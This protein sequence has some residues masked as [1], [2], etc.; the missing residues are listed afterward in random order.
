[1]NEKSNIKDKADQQR[2]LCIDQLLDD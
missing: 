2:I 1:L